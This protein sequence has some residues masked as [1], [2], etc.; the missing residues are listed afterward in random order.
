MRFGQKMSKNV[1]LTVREAL[2]LPALQDAKVVAGK[3][4]LNRQIR[5]VHI[6]SMP[7]ITPE[8]VP[9]LHGGELLL[10][11]GYG[12]PR[13]PARQRKTIR[14]FSELVLAG[15][16]FETGKFLEEVPVV[17]CREADR[18]GLPIL[19]A[20][21]ELKFV[22]V[23][24]AIH[25][26]ILERQ[27]AHL[28]QL[29]QINRKLTQAAVEA[30]NL[31][32]LA[33]LLTE[34]TGRAVAI[35][36]AEFALLVHTQAADLPDP[37][38]FETLQPGR[39]PQ[40]TLQAL[41]RM[42]FLQKLRE[43]HGT[44]R[45][46]PIPDLGM[47]SRV[48]CPI[49]T[50]TEILGYVSIFE[51]RSP[52]SE[53]DLRAT[54][55]TATLAALHIL[56]QQAVASVEDRVRY[57]FVDALLRGE[58]ERSRGLQERA[59]LLGFDRHTAY[60]VGILTVGP[61]LDRGRRWALTG[62]ADFE[63]RE[64]YGRIIR[65]TLEGQG[66]KPFLTFL[67]NQVVFLL[68]APSGWSSARTIIDRLWY[69]IRNHDPQIRLILTVGDIHEGAIGVSVSHSEADKLT[70]IV[71][72]DGVYFYH[73]HPLA[74]LLHSAEK[75]TL[76]KLWID[77]ASKLG[78]N[79]NRVASVETLLALLQTGF[80][81]GGTARILGIHRNTVRQ[82]IARIRQISQVSLE[83]P[84]FWAQLLLAVEAER[85]GLLKE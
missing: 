78:S 72:P 9:W 54:E 82:R 37:T 6:V 60:A 40:R 59:Q 26:A 10:T 22:D 7:E 51:G 69:V 52:V 49:R 25:R 61:S 74:Q 28:S 31:Q 45:I 68:S 24:E 15:V 34:L 4:G 80:D 21:Y 75:P 58:L 8:I 76:R 79:S 19:E 12:W 66:Q 27:Y 71:P 30:E 46:P 32:D 39:T 53:L 33:G 41:D 57:T 1:A 18:Q 17:V 29:E 20:P 11:A 65:G 23:T 35:E 14:A 47:E 77:V 85:Y 67:L 70:D 83:D 81:L 43:T 64:R 38:R 16:L 62:R 56:R 48:V 63:L 55:Q 5:W 13:D 2:T 36:T 44:L 42:G 3:R 50:A 84:K 73:E